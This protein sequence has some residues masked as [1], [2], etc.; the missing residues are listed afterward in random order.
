MN[1]DDPNWTSETHTPG[2]GSMAL[3]DIEFVTHVSHEGRGT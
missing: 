2:V 1:T 3:D